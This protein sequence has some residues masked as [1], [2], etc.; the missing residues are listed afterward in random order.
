MLPYL[1]VYILRII[2]EFRS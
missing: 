2:F 1:V